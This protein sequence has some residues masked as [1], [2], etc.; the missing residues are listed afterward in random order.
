M[1]LESIASTL[2]QIV[3]TN[4]NFHT[5]HFVKLNLDEQKRASVS[6]EN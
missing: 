6:V 2:E 3:K 4:L 1:S 5:A